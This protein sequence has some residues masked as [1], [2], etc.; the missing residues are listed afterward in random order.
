MVSSLSI[1]LE[2]KFEKKERSVR[3][4]SSAAPPPDFSSLM[5]IVDEELYIGFAYRKNIAANTPD[6]KIEIKK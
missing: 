1:L 4:A 5:M 3:A 2:L 6:S